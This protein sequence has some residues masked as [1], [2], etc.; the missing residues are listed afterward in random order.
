MAAL[1]G[2][3]IGAR[4][5]Q[6]EEFGYTAH[7][8][9]AQHK[10]IKTFI[11]SIPLILLYHFLDGRLT[12][13]IMATPANLPSGKAGCTAPP[14]N[15]PTKPILAP[16]DAKYVQRGPHVQ[17]T[18]NIQITSS[19]NTIDEHSAQ[20]WTPRHLQRQDQ[21]RNYPKNTHQHIIHKN[22]SDKNYKPPR[23]LQFP[24]IWSSR[25]NNR[26][27]LAQIW[28]SRHSWQ[29][30]AN[31]YLKNKRQNITDKNICN[32]KHNPHLLTLS[33]PNAWFSLQNNRFEITRHLKICHV[34]GGCASTHE[35]HL[36]TN[37]EILFAYS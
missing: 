25:Q 16:R 28:T 12:G 9:L 7:R 34:D 24:E 15:F 32:K 10:I 4:N 21:I 30:Q 6:Q 29:A 27:K 36:S 33:T 20:I 22:I 31:K 26:F 11:L 17:N 23:Y 18:H 8:A 3:A 14:T 37:V 35:D 5:S 1:F 13:P 2:P 19:N